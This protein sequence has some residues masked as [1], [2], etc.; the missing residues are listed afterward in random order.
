M[1][2]PSETH[3]PGCPAAGGYGHGIEPCICGA[4]DTRRTDAL[5]QTFTVNIGGIPT[6]LDGEWVSAEFAKQLERSLAEAEQHADYEESRANGAVE[7]LKELHTQLSRAK[8][9]LID[10]LEF[11]AKYE[12]VRDGQDGKQLPNQAMSLTTRLRSFLSD[13]KG[14]SHD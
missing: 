7:E 8:E 11:I 5:I 9:V 12:D 13:E 3:K 4:S 1:A 6:T 10:T 14:T 2:K